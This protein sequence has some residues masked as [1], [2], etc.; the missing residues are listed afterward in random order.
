MKSIKTNQRIRLEI[1]SKEREREREREIPL[2]VEN[3]NK[4]V[5]VKKKSLIKILKLVG[6]NRD[7][8]KTYLNLK[9]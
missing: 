9:I 7:K 4:N 2:I 3:K 6:Y 1:N 5:I 8:G